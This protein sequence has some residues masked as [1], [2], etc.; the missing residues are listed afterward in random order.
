MFAA[1]IVLHYGLI[2]NGIGIIACDNKWWQRDR[3]S[4]NYIKKLLRN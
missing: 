4:Q 1:L 3:E 2:R